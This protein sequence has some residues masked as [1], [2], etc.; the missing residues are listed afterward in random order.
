MIIECLSGAWSQ[1]PVATLGIGRARPRM[2]APGE[3]ARN[4]PGK[5]AA[6]ITNV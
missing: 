6:T 3:R 2:V 5:L 1:P 4:A